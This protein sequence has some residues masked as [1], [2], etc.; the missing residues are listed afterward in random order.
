MFKD[1][2]VKYDSGESVSLEAAAASAAFCEGHWKRPFPQNRI[3][4]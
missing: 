2:H 4:K 1:T 3:F